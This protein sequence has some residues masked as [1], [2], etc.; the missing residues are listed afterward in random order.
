MPPSTRSPPRRTTPRTP[1]ASA[2]AGS[3]ATAP[4]PARAARS[5]ASSST[6]GCKGRRR[7]VWISKSDKLIEDAAARLVGARPER[8][9]ITPL[10]PLPPGHADPPRGRHPIYHLRH[11]AHAGERESKASRVQQIV[12]WLG[13]DFDGV[14]VF[15]ESHAMAQRRRRQGRTRR[16]GP[17]AAGPR[18]PAAAAR[19][20]RTPASSTSPR[21][22]RPRSITSPTPQRL[23]LWGGEDF[24]FATRAEFVEAIEDGGVAAMEVLA[25][26]LKALGLY[27]A[28]SLSYE[29]VEYELVEHQLTPEQIRI[30]DAYAGAFSD[31][32]QQ[33][34]RGDAGRQHHRRDGHAERAGQVRRPLRLRI[35]QAALLQSSAHGDEDADADPR[36]SSAISRTAMPPSSRS[37]RP[38]RR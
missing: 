35:R 11:A 12:D 7:A 4:A 28:R 6:T 20:C 29:G 16:T 37:S 14:I 2:A 25:R 26:D 36:R 38:A 13:R 18:R 3:S 24:P 10:V 31:H 27:A 22:A 17:L 1:C 8:L 30:Y 23:G 34:R 21:P 15:D 5:P 32:P 9:L 33:S 19:A